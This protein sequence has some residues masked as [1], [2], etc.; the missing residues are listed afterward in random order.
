MAKKPRTINFGI[1]FMSMLL[2]LRI[3]SNIKPNNADAKTKR[4]ITKLSGNSSKSPA[5]AAAK[6]VPHNRETLVSAG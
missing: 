4:K 5:L 2:S 3:A 6:D 1:S